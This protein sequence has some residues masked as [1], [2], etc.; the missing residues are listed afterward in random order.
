MKH[1]ITK[2][3]AACIA[4]VCASGHAQTLSPINTFGVTAPGWLAPGDLGSNSDTGGST[5]RGIAYHGAS[6]RLI[7]VDRAAPDGPT[8]RILDGNTGQQVHTLSEGE[9]II[10]GGT[11]L[12]GMADVDDDGN[13]YV[14]NLATANTSNFRVYRWSS[15][16]IQNLTTEIPT[17]AHGTVSGRIRTGDSFAVIGSGVNTRL[18]SAGGSNATD[19]AFTLLTTNNGLNF[20]ASN[21]VVTGQPAGAFRLGIAFDGQGSVL[22]KQTGLPLW[23]APEAG[24]VAVSNNVADQ[25]ETIIGYDPASNLLAT[26]QYIGGVGFANTVR[27]YRW[28]DFGVPPV[29]LDSK[30]LTNVANPNGNA[31]GAVALGYGPG[32]KLRVYALNTNNGI[33]AFE[34]EMPA[35]NATILSRSVV[36]G[37][38][39]G[40]GSAVDTVKVLHKEDSVPTTLTNNNLIN[41]ARG[42]NGIQFEI[43][44][45]ANAVGLSASDF[46]FQVSPQGAFDEGTNLPEDW[47]A[48]PAPSGVSV[49]GSNPYVALV[50]WPDNAIR[51]RWLRITVKAN[52]NTGLA[53]DE[54]YYIGHLL[55]E[56]TGA[57]GPFT[58]AFADITPIRTAVGSTVG[59][60]NVADI[61]KNGTVAFADISSMRANVGTQLTAIT[62]P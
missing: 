20:T 39:S 21:P 43:Q 12:M 44:D 58:V 46:E 62:V 55:G 59:A 31:T 40:V 41:T 37:G 17:V 19:S 16:A 9:N 48:A 13:L 5:L 27:L 10:A 6:N 45:L 26:V 35:S 30:N 38:W 24:G 42:I 11:F 33:Q 50:Q 47:E 15:N 51:N 29:L 28:A 22:G 34:V 56:T 32:G 18:V 60:D 25:S 2:V 3:L 57:T 61:D 14:C 23:R 54:V 53:A 49:S 1:L 36:H 4:G 7:L 8:V 52:A